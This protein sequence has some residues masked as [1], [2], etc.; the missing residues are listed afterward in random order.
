MVCT[1]CQGHMEGWQGPSVLRDQKGYRGYQ[2]HWWTP[3]GVWAIWGHWGCQGLRGNRGVC[4][5]YQESCY[6]GTSRGIGASG[7]IQGS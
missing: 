5:S 6:S 4:G 7:G 2:G 3:R 1:G